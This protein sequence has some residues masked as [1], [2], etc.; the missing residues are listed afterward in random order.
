M[1]DVEDKVE[2]EASIQGRVSIGENSVAKRGATIRGPVI[3]GNKT[4]I[5][6]GVY[7]GPFTSIGNTV[8]I[9]RREIENSIIMDHC[10][11]DVEERIINSLIGPRSQIT[12]NFNNRPRGRRFIFE[13]PHP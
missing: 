1:H 10:T 7:L 5:E 9:K 12:S 4:I 8:T 13:R 11:I 2:D 3:I 6:G